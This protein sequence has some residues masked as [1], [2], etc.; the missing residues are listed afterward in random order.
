MRKGL[1]IIGYKD[2]YGSNFLQHLPKPH[3]TDGHPDEIDLREAEDFG[4]EMAVKS[5]RIYSGEVHLIPELPGGKTDDLLWQTEPFPYGEVTRVRS[6]AL[7]QR[8]VNME[9][10]RYPECTLCVDNCPMNSIDFSISPPKF[11]S[12]CFAEFFCEA[13]CPE[14]A[15]EVD[16]G[17]LAAVHD[18]PVKERCVRLLEEAEAK[19]R[20]RRL[21]PLEEV[22]WDTHLYEVTGHPRLIPE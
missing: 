16:F 11:K 1:T 13:I 8:K 2:W 10:C 12:N 22:G 3:L 20:F 14:G 21:V 19:G 7:K 17:P 5:R 4:R 6:I 15:I 9:K 18:I